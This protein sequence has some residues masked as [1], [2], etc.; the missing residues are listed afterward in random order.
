MII[1]GI[2]R[3]ETLYLMK[4]IKILFFMLG[5]FVFLGAAVWFT[6]S[7]GLEAGGFSFHMPT[8]EEMF[9]DDNIEYADVSE[10]IERQFNIDSVAVVEH[11]SIS[12]D[13]VKAV[14]PKA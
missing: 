11:D 12:G 6:P 3:N 1:T 14:V 9:L 4:P 10:I 5:V 7:D 13:T 2:N 8:F